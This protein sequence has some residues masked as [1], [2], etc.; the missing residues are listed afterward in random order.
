MEY[1]P[2]VRG[3]ALSFPRDE[4]AHPDFRTEWWYLT[5]WVQTEAGEPLGFQVTFFRSRPGL[6]ED[7]PSRFAARQLLFAHAALSNP[8]RGALLRGEKAA[9]E[10]FGLAE[11]QVGRLDVHI[12]DWTLRTERDRYVAFVRAQ[13][14]TVDIEFAP[15]QPILLQGEGGFSQKGPQAD[16]SSYYYSLPQLKVRGRVSIGGRAI[17]VTGLAWFDHEWSSSIMDEA[18]SGWDWLGLNLEDGGALMAFQMRNSQGREHWAAATQRDRS[19]QGQASAPDEVEW[20]PLR[21]WRSPRTG[22][23]YPVEWK[24]VVGERSI[25]LKPLMDDQENDAR[26]STGTLYW[27]GAVRALDERGLQIG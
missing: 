4:G 10:G 25:F 2:V 1:P 20:T 12:D 8:A 15:T 5:G 7:N 16:S 18:A 14:F 24:I 3:R 17:T 26:R 21:V 23:R 22:V 27:E 6:D 13:D 19:L 9:R 11:A